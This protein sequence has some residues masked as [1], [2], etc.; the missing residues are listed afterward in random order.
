MLSIY[1]RTKTLIRLIN[2]RHTRIGGTD[3]RLRSIFLNPIALR[4]EMASRELW[5]DAAFRAV[6][7]WREG[8]FL[9]VGANI[10]QTM[11]KVL[12]LDRA[13]QYVGFEPQISCSSVIQQFIDDNDLKNCTILPFG[14][15]TEN[16]TL[17]IQLHGGEY[18]SSASLIESFR[19]STFYKSYRYVCVRRGD[20]VVAELNLPSVAAVKIDVE[21]AELEVIEGL[22]NTI[23]RDQP[24]I[25]FEVLNSYLAMTGE[26]LDDQV[27]EFRARRIQKVETLLHGEGYDIYHVLAGNVLH[28]VDRIKPAVSADLALTNYIGLP[29]KYSDTFLQSFESPDQFLHSTK[30]LPRLATKSHT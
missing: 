30:P 23:R 9:D 10:G 16:R 28:R 18:D 19:P 21:G 17:K 13:R 4:R 12:A 14:L 7:R 8:A 11:L 26:K 25:I 2:S 20:D 29:A 3:Y 6:F 1:K 15:F 24:F 5:L 22:I 27:I